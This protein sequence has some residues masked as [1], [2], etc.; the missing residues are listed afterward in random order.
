MVPLTIPATRSTVSPASDWVS[1]R[2]TG[3]APATAASKYRSTWALSAACANSPVE[4]ASK[5]LFAVTTDLPRSRAPRIALRDG[6]TGPITSTTISTSSRATSSSMSSVNNSIGTPRSVVTRRTPMPRRTNG[7]PTRAARSSALFSM[8]RTTS[9][10]TLPKPS[11]A[12]PTGFSSPGTGHLTS[13]LSKS[14]TVSRRRTRRALPACTAT[15][16]GR[17]TML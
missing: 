16:A 10:P 3:M 11:T 7:A 12:T 1:G 13:K 14:S 6:S 9:L 15:T 17:P 8:M 5:A 2:M 4:V